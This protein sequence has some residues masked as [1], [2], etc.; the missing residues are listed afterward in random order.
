FPGDDGIEYEG[1]HIPCAESKGLVVLFHGYAACK[2]EL[3]SEA[4]ALRELGY[5]TFLVDFRASGG[6][7]GYETTVG[8]READD[9]A[10]AVDYAQ[11]QFGF[12]RVVLYGR[13]AGSAAILRAV[14]LNRV[15]PDGMILECPFDRLLSTV[16]HRF[17]AM[18]VPSFPAAQ[19]LVFWGG[20]QHG[21]S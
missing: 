11:A 12:S 5:D 21:Y 13:S 9:V 19:L 10:A 16:Q 14:S 7:S 20:V 17:S 2:C 4:S 18:G 1:W 8:Y 15:Y 6:S 3:L